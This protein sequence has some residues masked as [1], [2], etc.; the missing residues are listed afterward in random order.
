LYATTTVT[1]KFKR[2]VQ[3]QCSNVFIQVQNICFTGSL[4]ICGGTIFEVG[5]YKCTSKKIR[6]FLWFELQL[7]HH[8]HWFLMSLTFVSMFKQVYSKF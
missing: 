1:S 3:L 8:K 4:R 2:Y 5:W 6:K 7:W